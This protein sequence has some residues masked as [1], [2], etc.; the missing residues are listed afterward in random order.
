M[1]YGFL[2]CYKKRID[3]KNMDVCFF[4]TKFLFKLYI[5]DIKL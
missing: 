1:E 5:V 3:L 4:K 2:V